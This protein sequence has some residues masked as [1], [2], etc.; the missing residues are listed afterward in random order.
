MAKRKPGSEGW[1]RHRQPFYARFDAKLEQRI[2][3]LKAEFKSRIAELETRLTK[4]IPP[5][6]RLMVSAAERTMRCGVLQELLNPNRITRAERAK[7]RSLRSQTR[8]ADRR[9]T[10]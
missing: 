10:I 4:R 6:G 7:I 9:G 8:S 3:E 2:A 1:G 5:L